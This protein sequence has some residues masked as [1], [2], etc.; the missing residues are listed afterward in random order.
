MR[1]TDTDADAPDGAFSLRTA[2]PW[3]LAVRIVAVA[4]AV[5]VG[6]WLLVTLRGIV[7]QVLIAV[8][9]AAALTPLVERLHARVRLPRSPTV[10]L[11]YLGFV[12]ALVAL[13]LLIIPPVIDQ[14]LGIVAN[15]PAYEQALVNSLRDIQRTFPFL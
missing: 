12:L 7:L 14:I 3:T 6:L 13:A 1:A 15:A 5:V 10:L 8:I 11:I 4:T 9:L 2:R